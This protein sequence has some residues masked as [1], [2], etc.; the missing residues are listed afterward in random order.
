MSKDIVSIFCE[1]RQIRECIT[2][3]CLAPDKIPVSR[4]DVAYAVRQVY[5]LQRVEYTL[6]PLRSNTWKGHIE[7]WEG[8]VKI[9]LN[10]EMNLAETR[11]TIVKELGHVVVRN[12]DNKTEDVVALIEEMVLQAQPVFGIPPQ[13]T[14][15]LLAE[16]LAYYVAIELLFPF[17][18]R[19]ADKAAID[20]GATTLF[21]IAERL[22]IP[23]HVVGRALSD[24]Y[25]KL[26]SASW[27]QVKKAD[28]AA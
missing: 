16:N 18:L 4:D 5:G 11:F 17:E 25:H 24:Q 12:A 28:E 20:S 26:S 21:K 15:A 9:L 7:F 3:Y 23:E 2:Q 19:L 22:D 10:S 14:P 1:I 8:W 27:A 13:P 6:V